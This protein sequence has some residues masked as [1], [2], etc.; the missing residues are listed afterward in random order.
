MPQALGVPWDAR[1]LRGGLA[2]YIDV[3]GRARLRLAGYSDRIT[4]RV[5][6]VRWDVRVALG[7]SKLVGSLG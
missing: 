5:H 2:N 3:Y 7:A 1:Y 4:C 6:A